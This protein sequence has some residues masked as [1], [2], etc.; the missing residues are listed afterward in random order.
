LIVGS[1][2]IALFKPAWED[3]RAKKKRESDEAANGVKSKARG[4]EIEKNGHTHR[5]IRVVKFPGHEL[6]V[7][8]SKPRWAIVN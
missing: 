6:A 5:E 8:S 4:V 1:N 2:C 7:T 3:V